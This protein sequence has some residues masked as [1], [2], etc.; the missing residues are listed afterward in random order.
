LAPVQKDVLAP[1]DSTVVELVFNTGTVARPPMNLR[2]SANVMSNDA[3]KPTIPIY[4][5]GRVVADTDTVSTMVFKPNSFQFSPEKRKAE[6]F[7][8]NV[9]DSAALNVKPVGYLMDDFVIKPSDKAIGNGK[10]GK[11]EVEWKG[12]VP[13]YDVTRAITFETGSAASP[14]FSIAYS[15]KGTKGPRPAPPPAQAHKPPIK[16]GP[17]SGVK[18]TTASRTTSPPAAPIKADTTKKEV[19]PWGEKVWPPK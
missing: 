8:E 4:F 1:G 18:A 16:A 19:T 5:T 3:D 17:D 9:N 6:I 12:N 2:K 10:R 13:E 14:Y 15:I 7:F 11:V